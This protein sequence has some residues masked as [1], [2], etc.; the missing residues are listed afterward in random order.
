MSLQNDKKNR[1]RII[2]LTIF[3]GIKKLSHFNKQ[4]SLNYPF[5]GNETLQMHDK[6]EGFTFKFE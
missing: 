4:G 5:R 6:F 3:W 2:K 1:S